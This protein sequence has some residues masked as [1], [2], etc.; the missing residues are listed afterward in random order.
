APIKRITEEIK[1]KCKQSNDEPNFQTCNKCKMKEMN[2][3]S[4]S[5]S[6][7]RVYSVLKCESCDM[8]WN[9]N[10]NSALHI[11]ESSPL[12]KTFKK[13]TVL[14]EFNALSITAVHSLMSR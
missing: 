11:Y 6:K 13:L 2:N 8:V 10:V 3:F 4:V 9:R 1:R 14:S 12:Q 7:Q 5:V